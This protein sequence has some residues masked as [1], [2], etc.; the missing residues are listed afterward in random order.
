MKRKTIGNLLIVL[1]MLLLA[2]ALAWMGQNVADQVQAESSS[3]Q[4]LAQLEI[5]EPTVAQSQ[6]PVKP[7]LPDYQLNP[8][9]PMPETGIDGIAYI[10]TLEIPEL[11]LELPVISSTTNAYL[12]I[13]PCR[14]QGSAYEDNLVIGAHNYD[15]HFGRLKNLS[16]GDQIIVTDLDGNVFSYLVAD[17]EILQPNQTADL[18]GGGWPLTLYTC[19]VGGKTRVVIR[20]EKGQ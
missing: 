18:V 9:I 10:G 19:T 8:R 13:A 17:M 1:G 7:E 5:P 15:A 14:Y 16:Y 12:K 4:V 11:G 3:R 6:E 20:C 2:G